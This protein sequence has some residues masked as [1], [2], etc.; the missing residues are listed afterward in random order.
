MPM[1]VDVPLTTTL[2]DLDETLRRLLKRE[3]ARHGFENVE[4]AFDAPARE[5]SG[6]LTGPTVN[7]FLYDLREAT[8]GSTMTMA[9]RRSNGLAVLTP[10][11]LRL[12]ATYA[13]T[14]WTKAIE[15]EHRLLSQLLAV[16]HSYR[17]LPADVIEGRAAQLGPIDTVL[18][19]PMDEKA[20]FWSAVGG[21]YKP[22]IDF[23]VTLP[24]ESG[25]SFTRGPETRTQIVQTR[26]TEGPRRVMQEMIRFGGR[27]L[28]G[29]GEPVANAWV[30]LPDV[31]AWTSSDRDGR[32]IFD[33]VP[34][35]SLRVLARTA[36][37]T[38]AEQV[39]EV[40]GKET[41][42]VIGAGPRK[43][44]RGGSRSTK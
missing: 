24:L 39:V 15:D 40:P 25:A 4:I 27:I 2:A 16:L 8:Q 43:S 18:G 32:Y 26:L 35:G 5:W 10:P 21:Q 14:A 28:D 29:D 33:R 7:L 6:K 36:D 34:S 12:E 13:I 1:V 20:D 23:A 3:L 31:G 11:P 37:G 17:T 19:R 30:A 9:E 42:V 44:G 41:D 22:S 38:E